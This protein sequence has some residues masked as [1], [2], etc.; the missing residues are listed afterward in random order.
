[1]TRVLGVLILL[2]AGCAPATPEPVDPLAR[3]HHQ[4]PVFGECSA[5][6]T[7]GL[8]GDGAA[9]AECATLE[10]PLDYDDPDGAT[11]RIA[12]LRIPARGREPVGSLVL[13]PGGPGFSG[14][15][16]APLM[17]QTWASS[18]IVQRFDLIGFDPRGVGA[19]TPTLDC[20][21]DAERDDDPP[22]LFFG[23]GSEQSA[24]HFVDGCAANAGAHEALAR[25][26]TRDVARDIDVL[27]AVLGDGKLTF[28]GG[29]YGTRVG[30]TYAEMFPQNVRALV[31]DGAL[32]PSLS[33]HDRRVRQFVGLQRS[34]ERL[35]AFCAPQRGCPLGTDPSAATAVFQ[36][37]LRPLLDRPVPAGDGRELTFAKAVFG[38]VAG[39][40]TEVAW[41]VMIQG[42][43]ELGEGRGDT[44]LEAYDGYHERR[45]DGSYANSLEA[46]IGINCV[47]EDRHTAAQE[48]AMK[49]AMVDAAPFLDPGMPVSA[50]DPCQFWPGDQALDPLLPGDIDGLPNTLT[51]SV[52]GDP[53]F[54]HSGGIALA[55]A[56]GGTLL[57][58][59]GDRHG[60][61]LSGNPCVDQAVAAYLVDL[62]T[63]P[64][65][66]RC[67][68]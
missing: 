15:S 2:L 29:S 63:P 57:T 34:F 24:R 33:A 67:E 39:M 44:L 59:D 10:V 19:S 43:T 18:P 22:V 53:A 61:V 68:L 16:F 38:V 31:L 64:E 62:A 65:S 36:G 48:T 30:T 49:Q 17:A 25:V 5:E 47:D 12:V 28:V 13:N 51:I 35:A 21:D 42:I 50:H 7:G 66:A 41:P 60:S 46:N 8:D 37:L 40:Y 56:L 55:H 14:T 45:P 9:R 52:T 58:V 26:G 27:R 11:A 23:P 4:Q 1:M 54:P 3:F 20:L 6:A 32:D